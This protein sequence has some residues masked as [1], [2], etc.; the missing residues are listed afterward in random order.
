MKLGMQ[1]WFDGVNGSG[2]VLGRPIELVAL[3]DGYE[4]ARAATNMR[5]LIDDE[6]VFAVLGNVG[7]P[8]AA[9]TVPIANE[10]KVPLFGAFTG[11]GLLRK[12]PPDRYILNYRASYA[13][14]TA[15]MVRGLV[16]ELRIKLEHI[17]FFTQHDAYG[18][19]GWS[20]GV[21]AL[22]AHG[23]VNAERQPHG[24]YPRNTLDVEEGLSKLLDPRVTV[25]AVIM[26]GAYAPCA[27][28][29]RLAGKSGL[30]AIYCN[31][32]FVGSDAL[33][34]A[35]GSDGSG[36]VITQ[37]VPHPDLDLEI[38]RAFRQAIAKEHQGVVALEGYIVGRALT[39]ALRLAG[40]DPTRER[41]IDVLE[42]G[43]PIDLGLGQ[44]HVLSKSDHQLS[45]QLWLTVISHGKLLPLRSWKELGTV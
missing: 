32:S 19:A 13:Q 41:F 30:K 14:E 15:E 44:K 12:T 24:R 26:V 18:D 20:G 11:A 22:K 39:E 21:K 10:K 29:I 36:T 42:A 5:K 34:R 33:T 16:D 27:E 17:A 25:R 35:L 2:G 40:E 23:L 43:N 1:A 9:V 8:T 4:P 38:T 45:D 7:T 37:V 28:F 6:H 3:D 31:V